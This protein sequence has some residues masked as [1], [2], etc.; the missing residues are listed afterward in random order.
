MANSYYSNLG[1]PYCAGKP[2]DPNV[3]FAPHGY[4]L[5]VDTELYDS[6]VLSIF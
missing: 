5:V 3:A 6:R 4:V 1:I 2:D